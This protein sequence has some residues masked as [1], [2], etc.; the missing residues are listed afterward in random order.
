MRVFYLSKFFFPDIL[1][2][3]KIEIRNQ[4]T[5]DEEQKKNIYDERK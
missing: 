3:K 4:R 2:T 5:E 1:G